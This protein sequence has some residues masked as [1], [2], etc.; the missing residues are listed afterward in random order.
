M[1]VFSDF[2]IKTAPDGELSVW[3]YGK[4]R[5]TGFPDYRM[6][7]SELNGILQGIAQSVNP[8]NGVC[9]EWEAVSDSVFEALGAGPIS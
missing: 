1:S 3:G 7:A 4:Q 2:Q 9:A 5:F 8:L 6:V